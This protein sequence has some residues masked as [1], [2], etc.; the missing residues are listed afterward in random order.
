VAR[1]R[2]LTRLIDQIE[3]LTRELEALRLR[4]HQ[5]P[6]LHA[7]ERAREHLRWKL[8][9]VARRAAVEFDRGSAP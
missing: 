9:V 6:N 5:E 4:G 7:K 8:A 2:Q 1:A 3:A